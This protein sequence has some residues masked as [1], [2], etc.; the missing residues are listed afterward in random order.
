MSNL[1]EF[2]W[3]Y[4]WRKNFSVWSSLGNEEGIERFSKLYV[5]G[6]VLQS[7]LEAFFL[8]D[9]SRRL[10]K[11]KGS[12]AEVGAFKGYSARLICEQ[13]GNKKFYLF[14]TFEGFQ[15]EP[16]EVDEK[17]SLAAK[18]TYRIGGLKSSLEDVKNLLCNYNQVYIHKGIFPKTGFVVKDEFFALVHL[19]VDLYKSTKDALE[20]FYSRMVVGGCIVIH[21]YKIF[22]GV[23]KA[24]DEFFKDKP[25]VVLGLFGSQAFVQKV[26]G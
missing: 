24:V 10:K 6:N 22:V 21:D 9:L 1:G 17:V 5:D 19:D 13:K 8:F 2:V 12:Y 23:R 20:F 4:F 15:T 18:N 11:L 7:K 3:K 25:E 16:L 26:V 14:D